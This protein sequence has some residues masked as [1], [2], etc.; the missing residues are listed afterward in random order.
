M[1]LL[2]ARDHDV[3]INTKDSRY[4]HTPLL[5]RA[6]N[7]RKDM[8][9]LLLTRDDVDVNTKDSY[10]GRTPLPWVAKNGH[11]DVVQLLLARDDVDVNIKSED[12]KTAADYARSFRYNNIFSLFDSK[13]AT[14]SPI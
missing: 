4:G 1:Q 13:T 3:D 9:Q 10:N 7:G 14:A 5:W 11:K 6:E 2:L 12:S 8:V